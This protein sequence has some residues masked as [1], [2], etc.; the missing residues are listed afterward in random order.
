MFARL[1]SEIPPSSNSSKTGLFVGPVECKITSILEYS[2]HDLRI[3]EWQR[4]ENI[5]GKRIFFLVWWF[6]TRHH[7]DCL[8]QHNQNVLIW[9][10]CVNFVCEIHKPRLSKRLQKNHTK[11][12][13]VGSYDT[14]ISDCIILIMPEWTPDSSI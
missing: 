14:S 9:I 7:I 5:K 6:N 8:V 11:Q 1:H 13:I 3:C 12:R 10:F 2:Y 4:H